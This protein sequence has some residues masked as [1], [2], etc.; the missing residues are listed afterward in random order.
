M[1]RKISVVGSQ[2]G[3]GF[4]IPDTETTLCMLMQLGKMSYCATLQNCVNEITCES[5]SI[6]NKDQH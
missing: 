2:P 1:L 3:V 5:C 4:Y 6:V